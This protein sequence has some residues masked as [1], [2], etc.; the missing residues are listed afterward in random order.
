MNQR[1]II[2]KLKE[3]LKENGLKDVGKRL[4]IVN[5]GKRKYFD[6]S[7]QSCEPFGFSPNDIVKTLY[8]LAIV[9]GVANGSGSDRKTK[10]LWFQFYGSKGAT[11][12]LCNTKEEFEKSG[13]KFIKKIRI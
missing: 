4:Y 2:K 7:Q 12:C 8:G 3:K 1:E 10:K 5:N 9:V 6:I 13:F 11:Y